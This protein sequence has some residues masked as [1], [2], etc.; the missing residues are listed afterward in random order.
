[1]A[2][3]VTPD[4]A[5]ALAQALS[6]ENGDARAAAHVESRQFDRPQRLSTAERT[7]L[8]EKLR[9]ALAEIAR[10]LAPSMRGV[11]A[12]ELVELTEAHADTVQDGLVE[13]FAVARFD[14]AGQPGWLVWDC[15]AALAMLDVA[16][17]A[18]EPGK[19]AARPFTSIER[20]MFPRAVQGALTR[21]GNV[22]GLQLSAPTA[23]QTLD[24]LGSWRQGG[25]KSEP[26]RLLIT[27]SIAGPGGASTW[28]L[29]VPGI[30]H[31]ERA[32]A[33]AERPAPLPVHLNEVQ[34]EVRA[35][36][37]AN[38]VPLAE[39][40]ALEVGDVIPLK[41]SLGEPLRVLVED[42]ACLRA[43]LGRS[44]GRLALRVLSVERP[45][46]EA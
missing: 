46:P 31:S 39:L 28:R 22:L 6:S 32:P 29:Y 27:L 8:R 34:V 16:L 3:N 33:R 4:E 40:L 12:I 19:A 9:R 30:V 25:D 1:L 26:Q 13:P 10:E 35:H 36:L 24:S 14:V 37:G 43:T 21:I 2:T 42:Q 23:V 7:G 45:K 20:A 11:P 18:A 44:Q 17:G 41:L 15:A 5:R 38:E